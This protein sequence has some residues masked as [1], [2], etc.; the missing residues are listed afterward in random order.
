MKRNPATVL[1]TARKKA[2]ALIASVPPPSG[3]TSGFFDFLC[4]H[5]ETLEDSLTYLFCDFDYDAHLESPTA[6]AA[7]ILAASAQR[8]REIR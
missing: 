2:R 4:N 3:P 8:F 7:R 1:T 6:I 5:S